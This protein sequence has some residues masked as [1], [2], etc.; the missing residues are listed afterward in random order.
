[1][2][3]AERRENQR[4]PCVRGDDTSVTFSASF[5]TLQLESL[6]RSTPADFL[7]EPTSKHTHNRGCRIG[8][9]WIVHHINLICSF[10][11]HLLVTKQ[12]RDTLYLGFWLMTL[13][14]CSFAHHILLSSRLDWVFGSQLGGPVFVTSLGQQGK[15]YN[16]KC[17]L[18]N[19]AKSIKSRS[20]FKPCLTFF[21][22]M[23]EVGLNIVLF[24]QTF[25]V[26]TKVVEHF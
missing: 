6:W 14:N 24:S 13:L 15:I 3:K 22:G 10:L 7:L 18:Y 16:A 25:V 21:C 8:R 4:S 23:K 2:L 9:E 12:I 1:M 26:W 11:L 20:H 5:F 17:Y 19:H